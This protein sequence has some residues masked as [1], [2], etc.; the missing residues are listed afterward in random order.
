MV[1][2]SLDGVFV[3]VVDVV[4]VVVGVEV[5]ADAEEEVDVGAEDDG[6]PEDD[7]TGDDAADELGE[8]LPVEVGEVAERGEDAADEDTA[9][10]GADWARADVV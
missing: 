9:D 4:A 1:W 8:E 10:S 6:A 2:L 7:A 5:E 3:D